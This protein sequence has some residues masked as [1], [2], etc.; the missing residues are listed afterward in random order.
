MPLVSRSSQP[1]QD[2]FI[3]NQNNRT[4][5]DVKLEQID[6][7]VYDMN[8]AVYAEECDAFDFHKMFKSVDFMT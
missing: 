1:R 8:D 4:N 2:Q 7:G 5:K 3:A 6:K